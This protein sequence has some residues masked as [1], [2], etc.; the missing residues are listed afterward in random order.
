LF[1]AGDNVI[2]SDTSRDEGLMFALR[3]IGK[4]AAYPF[5]WGGENG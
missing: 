1:L 3:W 5:G 2:A 4:S